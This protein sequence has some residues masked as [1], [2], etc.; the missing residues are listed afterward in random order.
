MQDNC[1]SPL[2]RKQGGRKKKVCL[3]DGYHKCP[4]VQSE[5]KF[6]DLHGRIA[7]ARVSPQDHLQ[8]HMG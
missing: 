8:E 6:E 3:G 2:T 7:T 4:K 1:D 5:Q